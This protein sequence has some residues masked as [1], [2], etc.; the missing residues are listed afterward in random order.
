MILR[1]DEVT[2]GLE[3]APNR[4]LLKAMGMVDN[5]IDR[6]FIGV[7]NSWSKS[8]PG[9]L[10]VAGRLDIPQPSSHEARSCPGSWMMRSA[11]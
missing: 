9:H 6:P 10:M 11:I 2:K 3:R 8:I 5:E 1:S 4:S 7:V